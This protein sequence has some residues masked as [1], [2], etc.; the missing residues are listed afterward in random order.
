[1]DRKNILPPRLKF[2]GSLGGERWYGCPHCNYAIEAREMGKLGEGE[3]E[4]TY[5]CPNCFHLFY[6]SN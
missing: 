1:M 5:H 6:Y 4:N 3:K 2:K